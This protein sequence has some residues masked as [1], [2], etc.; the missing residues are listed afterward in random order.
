M[1]GV[2]VLVT[3]LAVTSLGDRFRH[4]IR[5]FARPRFMVGKEV[6]LR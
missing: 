4:R 5:A 3:L 2:Q 6:L 1:I